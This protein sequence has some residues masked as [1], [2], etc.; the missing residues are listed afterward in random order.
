MRMEKGPFDSWSCSVS[1][2]GMGAAPSAALR[3]EGESDA[4]IGVRRR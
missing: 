4:V 3:M 2:L 1:S